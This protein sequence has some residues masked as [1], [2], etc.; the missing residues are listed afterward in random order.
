MHNLLSTLA[1]GIAGF[2]IM[3]ALYYFGILFT[4]V[5]GKIRNQEI[6]EVALGFGDVYVSAFLGLLTGWPAIIGVILLAILA[7]G[8]FSFVYILVMLITRRYRSFS[9]IPYT[10]FLIIAAITI[11]YIY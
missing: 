9:A 1:G 3:L 2:M 7:S 11:F 10:P 8:A 4:K 5:M 6:E